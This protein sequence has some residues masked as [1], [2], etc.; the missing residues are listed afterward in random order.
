MTK[1]IVQNAIN[2][3]CDCQLKIRGFIDFMKQIHGQSCATTTCKIVFLFSLW[4]NFLGKTIHGT[5][6]KNFL[7]PCAKKMKISL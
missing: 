4:K 6:K 5:K 3:I 1:Q 2:S 7:L